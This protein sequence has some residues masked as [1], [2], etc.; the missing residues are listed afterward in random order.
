MPLE[1]A[2][3]A[4]RRCG[5]TQDAA[6]LALYRARHSVIYA[7]QFWIDLEGIDERVHTHLVRSHNGFIP[8]VTSQR[9]D[10]GGVPGLRDMS[11]LCNAEALIILAQKRLCQ[12]AWSGTRLVVAA[13]RGQVAKLDPDLAAVMRP[14][15]VWER[16][17]R[18]AQPC[19]WYVGQLLPVD[20]S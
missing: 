18:E 5:A 10:R 1:W 20:S 8:W 19:G 7:V 14:R 12:R 3:R 9:P 16:G 17:C 2:W 4:M 6:P 15:C 13:I 11:I